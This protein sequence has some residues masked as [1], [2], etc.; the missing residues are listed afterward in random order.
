MERTGM[1]PNKRVIAV[2]GGIG[3]GKSTVCKILSAYGDIL[4]CDAINA[5]MLADEKYLL[6]LKK[7]FPEAFSESGIPDK[8]AIASVIF[9]DEKK[10]NELDKLAHPE[11]KRRLIEKIKNCLSDVIF[12]EVPILTDSF[13]EMF[14]EIIL[15]TA[16]RE[17]R[18]NRICQRDNVNRD[19]AEKK[20]DGQKEYTY[21]HSCVYS[22]DNSGDNNTLTNKC[23]ELIAEIKKK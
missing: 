22:I 1:T 4:S 15:V 18:I 21:T 10:R 13:A 8:R 3:S 6:Q 2:T 23:R 20:I 12:V 5:E 19:F 9:N 14:S 11:I 17:T 16:D 7:I